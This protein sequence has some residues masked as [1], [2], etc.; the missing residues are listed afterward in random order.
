MELGIALDIS[1]A[2]LRNIK[3]DYNSNKERAY[4]V[5]FQWKDKE[6][7]R[8]TSMGHLAVAFQKIGRNDI[9]HFLIGMVFFV[10]FCYFF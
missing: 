10:C 9:V 7:T 8:A 2:A 3:D 4:A 5:F 1:G 6:E